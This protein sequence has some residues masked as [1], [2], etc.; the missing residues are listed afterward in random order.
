MESKERIASLVVIERNNWPERSKRAKTCAPPPPFRSNHVV[1][2]SLP[3]S[4]IRISH[5]ILLS[6][7]TI[8]IEAGKVVIVLAGRHAGKKAVVVKTFD[9]DYYLNQ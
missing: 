8:V 3:F 5:T 6:L 1:G 9:D 2:V 7:S 4:S